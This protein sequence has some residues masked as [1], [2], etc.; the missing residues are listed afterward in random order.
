MSTYKEA[1]N[2]ETISLLNNPSTTNDTAVVITESEI[3]LIEMPSVAAKASSAV[4]PTSLALFK[5]SNNKKLLFDSA[6]DEMK[7]ITEGVSALNKNA[8]MSTKSTTIPYR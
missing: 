8:S 7:Q 2:K 3:P 1:K 6:F 5:N 4:P